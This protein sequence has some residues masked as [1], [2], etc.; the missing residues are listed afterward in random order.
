VQNEERN[1]GAAVR[2]ALQGTAQ[3]SPDV[4]VIV[5]DG[6]SGDDTVREARRAGA[7]VVTASTSGRATQMNKGA[8]VARGDVIMFLHADSVLPK[9]YDRLVD[10]S[11]GSNKTWGC[12]RSIH[13]DIRNGL[14]A[15]VIRQGVA[16]R[17]QLFHRPYGDQCI[18]VKRNVF[19]ELGGYRESMPLLEDVDLVTR[20]SRTGRGPA[21]VPR[22]LTTSGRRWNKLGV[23]QTT[24]LNQYIL[25]RH[26]MGADVAKLAELY[27]ASKT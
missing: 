9:E 20:L 6:H 4:E 13:I 16:L 27:A 17:T 18:F 24:I 14:L 12:F 1:V 26:A 11:L 25:L 5:V 7:T 3:S 19:H 23:V 21:I 22:D 15:W 10:A 2:S 8:D